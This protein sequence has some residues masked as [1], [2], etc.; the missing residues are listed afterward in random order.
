MATLSHSYGQ[1]SHAGTIEQFGNGMAPQGG[2]GF[3]GRPKDALTST[4]EEYFSIP[5]SKVQQRPYSGYNQAVQ[6]IEDMFTGRSVAMERVIIAFFPAA[7]QFPLRRLL[8]WTENGTSLVF[9]W[10]TWI[11]GNH[12]LSIEP[13]FAVPRLVTSASSTNRAKLIRH[14]IGAAIELEALKTARGK[15][16]LKY[17]VYQIINA[18]LF[19]MVLNVYLALLNPAIENLPIHQRARTFKDVKEINFAIDSW[20]D[21]FAGL[22]KNP[23]FLSTQIPKM[24]KIM[25]QRCGTTGNCFS[26]PNGTLQYASN[27]LTYRKAVYRSSDPFEGQPSLDP[28]IS[29]MRSVTI[30]ESPYVPMGFEQPPVDALVQRKLVALFTAHDTIH[31]GKYEFGKF[32]SS[33]MDIEMYSHDARDYAP[34]SYVESLDFT[35]LFENELSAVRRGPFDIKESA[36]GR[37]SKGKLSEYGSK[38]L[39]DL[40][41]QGALLDKARVLVNWLD[42]LTLRTDAGNELR[43]SFNRTFITN[44]KKYEG[45]VFSTEDYNLSLLPFG[46]PPAAAGGGGGLRPLPRRPI[47]A[48]AGA[49]A[50]PPDYNKITVESALSYMNR[51][52]ED[53]P[54]GDPM[55]LFRWTAPRLVLM[56]YKYLESIPGAQ[57]TANHGSKIWIALDKVMT[58]SNVN[59]AVALLSIL[60]PLISSTDAINGTRNGLGDYAVATIDSV[61]L[62]VSPAMYVSNDTVERF[63]IGRIWFNGTLSANPV[64]NI[65]T[66]VL[67]L[68][69]FP[70]HEDLLVSTGLDAVQLKQ[71]V[72]LVLNKLDDTDEYKI[73]HDIL[74]I[75]IVRDVLSKAVEIADD[76]KYAGGPNTTILPELKISIEGLAGLAA[77]W[78]RIPRFSTAELKATRIPGDAPA[79]GS[80]AKVGGDAAIR[81]RREGV[82]VAH[83]PWTQNQL[84]LTELLREYT[85]VED[86][87]AIMALRSSALHPGPTALT[88]RELAIICT[89]MIAGRIE[90]AKLYGAHVARIALALAM[91]QLYDDK[92][93]FDLGHTIVN[94]A[95][96]IAGGT[97]K[98]ANKFYES[99][100]GAVKQIVHT[101]VHLY[102]GIYEQW[103]GRHTDL[104]R[105][106][107]YFSPTILDV[108]DRMVRGAVGGILPTSREEFADVLFQ[109]PI[110]ERLISWGIKEGMHPIFNVGL[111]RIVDLETGT[112]IYNRGDGATGNTIYARQMCM[113]AV[114]TQ[115]GIFTLH[116]T[117]WAKCVIFDASAII[118][119]QDMIILGYNGGLGLR[120]WDPRDPTNHEEFSHSEMTHDIWCVPLFQWEHWSTEAQ[121]SLTG[122]FADHLRALSRNSDPNKLQFTTALHFAAM[123]NFANDDNNLP[124]DNPKFNEIQSPHG[125]TFATRDGHYVNGQPK[126]DGTASEN[127]LNKYVASTSPLGDL[128]KG[129]DQSWRGVSLYYPRF[130]FDR[131]APSR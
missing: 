4:L 20:R 59:S 121:L 19:T 35:G 102:T 60:D 58:A 46:R 111:V 98:D 13:S 99:N 97:V 61:T 62:K 114:N 15:L 47:A 92:P 64:A 127:Q 10:D 67:Y 9:E 96:L 65:Y 100:P 129:V 85:D 11:F 93:T 118:H 31:I 18:V 104:M 107:K 52:G 69:K 66:Q 109:M 77:A 6:S 45:R 48:A 43:D 131:K 53:A 89:A 94:T 87:K 41:S 32:K 80:D 86:W 125:M 73:P 17:H 90:T 44:E 110:D 37:G 23:A 63:G 30:Q 84:Q 22:Q 82:N 49:R 40:T 106:P 124:L 91:A 7:K 115:Q 95:D 120:Y 117:L 68:R 70:K 39:Q 56:L 42:T 54:R 14:G 29:A 74:T 55:A 16:T 8:P 103:M 33:Q 24:D 3:T 57:L 28:M 72:G 1:V 88:E 75:G 21:E 2:N 101:F 130:D 27:D 34:V 26:M 50:P 25:N 128:C 81:A 51:L 112:G 83:V 79:D 12:L 123:W 71:F 5:D 116:Y 38:C 126:K 78:T 76:L 119:A 36:G 105:T 113:T 122:R 108:F